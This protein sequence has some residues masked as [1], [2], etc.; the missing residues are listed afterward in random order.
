M[1][2]YQKRVSTNQMTTS[3]NKSAFHIL[4][5]LRYRTYSSGSVF[6][7]THN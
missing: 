7:E 1:P 2:E 4:K 3:S 6:S 5:G